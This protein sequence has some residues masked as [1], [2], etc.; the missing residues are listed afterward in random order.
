[1]IQAAIRVFECLYETPFDRGGGYGTQFRLSAHFFPF[2]GQQFCVG[3]DI[4]LLNTERVYI[5]NDSANVPNVVGILNHGDQVLAP[6]VFNFIGPRAERW[7]GLLFFFH[8]YFLSMLGEHSTHC[9]K[10]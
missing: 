6:E 5:P 4:S 8:D 1:V 3:D 2:F 10:T 9:I 7:F